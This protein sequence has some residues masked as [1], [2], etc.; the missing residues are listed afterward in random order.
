MNP[1]PGSR[2][3][4]R[5]LVPAAIA[6][7]PPALGARVHEF[8]GQTMGTTWSVRLVAA[9]T[10]RR[11]PVRQAIQSA[12]DEVVAQMSTWDAGSDLCR[13][14]RA[15]AG[16]WHALPDTFHAV[17]ACAREV[18]EHSDGAFDPTAGALV[19][20]WGFGPDARLGV[21]DPAVLAQARRAAGWRRIDV[22]PARRALLQPGA[23][24]LDLSA[25]AKGFGVDHVAHRLDALGLSD[26]LVEVGGE[27]RGSGVKPDGQPWWVQLEQPAD[28][29]VGEQT[30][31]ALHG[32]SVA[33]SGD[34]RRWFEHD[35]TRY[36]HTIDPRDGLPIRHGL[37]SV[38]V[39]HADCMRADAWSTAL[40]V[41][42]PDV[43]PALADRRGLAARF[44]VREGDGFAERRSAAFD[45][46]LR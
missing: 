10:L 15:A 28:D 2:P 5:V 7:T 43:G 31:L 34:Y 3:A 22:D 1:V 46:L 35:G 14:N 33:T 13:F 6:A 27:L 45:A 11:E 9:L 26:H 44:L 8:A 38:T 21:P 19:D 36:S 4:P 18:A 12:L 24:A 17:L 29:G 37:A 16:S 39:I 25:I 42:G 23:L 30:L 40:T 32:L 41:L 20:A